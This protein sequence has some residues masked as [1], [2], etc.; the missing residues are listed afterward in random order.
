MTGLESIREDLE[1]GDRLIVDRGNVENGFSITGIYGDG[2]PQSIM[3][4][5]FGDDDQEFLKDI[6]AKL[7]VT[8]EDDGGQDYD[9]LLEEEVFYFSKEQEIGWIEMDYDSLEEEK[10]LGGGGSKPDSVGL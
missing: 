3:K 9:L 8:G 10:I 5:A 2:R 7:H 6:D 1:E 4:T